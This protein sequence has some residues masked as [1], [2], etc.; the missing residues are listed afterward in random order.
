M[1]LKTGNDHG[2]VRLTTITG[3][4]VALAIIG[5]AG[6]DTFGIMSAHVAT[7]NDA[8]NA[9]YAASQQWHL[10]RNIDSAYQAAV[11]YVAGKHETVLTK[12]FTV[13]A[14]GTVHLL[15]RVKADTVVAQHIGPL[16]KETIVTVHGDANSVN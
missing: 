14:D 15:V 12:D 2:L 16:K 9:A 11:T 13:D 4:L 10:N 7:E 6:F 5:V 3:W 1:M 8:Q